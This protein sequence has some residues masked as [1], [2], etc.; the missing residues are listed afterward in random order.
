MSYTNV[1]ANG[2]GTD[3]PHSVPSPTPTVLPLSKSERLATYGVAALVVS[4]MILGFINSFAAIRDASKESFG[5]LAFTVPLGIDLGVLAFASLNLVL[6]RMDMSVRWLRLIPWTLTAVTVYLNVATEHDAFGIVAHA[7]LPCLWIIPVEV[8]AIVLAHRAGLVAGTHMDS[9]RASR[10]VLAPWSTWKLWRRMILW[11]MRSYPDAVRRERE[12]LLTLAD[13]QER[14]GALAWRWRTPRRTRVLYRLGDAV[15]V[16]SPVR[17]PSVP[18]LEGRTVRRP[19]TLP[20][21]TGAYRP[22]SPVR[23]VPEPVP[24]AVPVPSVPRTVR[25]SPSPEPRTAVPVRDG[26]DLLPYGRKVYEALQAD[27]TTI[28]RDAFAAALR[29]AG[30]PVSSKRA[31]DLLRTIKAEDLNGDVA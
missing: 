2:E 11:D 6:A 30:T 18:A 17:P 25:P 16:P 20:V 31:G 26:T 28:T 14:Y 4:L 29:S 24:S 3:H 23:T 7:V 1:T 21:R 9:V 15:P 19:R 5:E 8:G 27:G 10:W 12:R 13:L 22:P